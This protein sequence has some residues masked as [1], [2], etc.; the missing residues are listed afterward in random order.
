MAED[1]LHLTHIRIYIDI[2][3]SLD[4]TESYLIV[5]RKLF[6]YV[7]QHRDVLARHAPFRRKLYA[8][9]VELE[10]A[11]SMEPMLDLLQEVKEATMTA[12]G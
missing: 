4:H 5:M 6:S 11:P 8:M 3:Q 9:V 12:T 2:M 10:E 7:L 1:S